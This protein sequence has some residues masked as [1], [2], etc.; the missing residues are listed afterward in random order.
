M[1][2]TI[3]F[4]VTGGVLLI[5]VGG[6]LVYWQRGCMP[7]KTPSVLTEG[8]ERKVKP[9]ADNIVEIV[10]PSSLE[11]DDVMA[12][13]IPDIPPWGEKITKNHIFW[14][15]E[16][17]I[18]YPHRGFIEGF[19][20]SWHGGIAW[21]TR[22]GTGIETPKNPYDSILSLAVL[23]YERPEFAKEDYE[24]IVVGRGYEGY[25]LEDAE[26]KIEV[27][28]SSTEGQSPQYLLH[29]S[30]FIIYAHGLKGAAEDAMIRAIDQYGVR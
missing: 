10:I 4:L 30:N 22:D 6:L 17:G 7:E 18:R 23:K 19:A 29:S 15:T 12:Q 8:S 5:L 14:A 24:R 11:S 13:F 2:K 20:T 28:L 3:L 25:I 21:I 16:F 9:I 26:L 27:R 1:S